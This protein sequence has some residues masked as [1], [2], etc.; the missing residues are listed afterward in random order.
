MITQAPLIA[1]LMLRYEAGN[2]FAFVHCRGPPFHLT[3]KN[4]MSGLAAILLL[5]VTVKCNWRVSR[6]CH[7]YAFRV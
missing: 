4:Q 7:G 1:G 5:P 2:Y 3:A 6:L